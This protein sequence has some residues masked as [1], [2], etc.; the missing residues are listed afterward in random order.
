[1]NPPKTLPLIYHGPYPYEPDGLD[2]KGKSFS[3]LSNHSKG[4]SS[5]TRFTLN[6]F[7]TVLITLFLSPLFAPLSQAAVIQTCEGNQSVTVGS[8]VVG[9]NYWNPKAC[10]GRQCIAINDKTG[11]FTVTDDSFSCAPEVASYPFIFY[12]SHFGSLS[13]NSILPMK[14]TN[15][16]NVTTSWDFQSPTEGSW[17]AAYDVWF[18]RGPST[19]GGFRGGAELMIWLDYRG[20]VP[21]AGQKVGQVLID[22]KN[23]TLWE[24]PIGWNYIAYLADD[25]VTS[26]KDLDLM[27]FLKDSMSRGF[28]DSSWYLSAVEA[29]DEL[30][31]GGAPFTSH[32]FSVSVN[33]PPLN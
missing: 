20:N 7:K 27:N 4:R 6:R 17:D 18:S 31:T 13:P 25:P 10:G 3:R 12:G 33:R 32:S 9:T 29:G 16:K 19:V 15:L 11:S 22:G 8:Y 21:P 26:V 23:W 14:I 30:R 1:M 5:L 24:G 2:F 28:I